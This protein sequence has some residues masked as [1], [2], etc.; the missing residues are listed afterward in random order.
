MSML[1]SAI[2]DVPQVCFDPEGPVPKW[3]CP[4][5]FC[6]NHY[7]A[8]ACIRCKSEMDSGVFVEYTE[9]MKDCYRA[10]YVE[11]EIQAIGERRGNKG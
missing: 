7:N 1:R 6:I 2:S 10:K 11:V 5:C 4:L 9:S 3:V 8:S